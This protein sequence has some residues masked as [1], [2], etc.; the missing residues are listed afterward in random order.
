MI[1]DKEEFEIF[2]LNF[3]LAQ[4]KNIDDI[5]IK[6]IENQWAI[7]QSFKENNN[8]RNKLYK[9]SQLKQNNVFD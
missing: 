5:D 4:R 7:Y 6:E 8:E 1:L 3:S 9:E 2:S